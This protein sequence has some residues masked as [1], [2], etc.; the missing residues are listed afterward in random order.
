M[1]APNRFMKN[2]DEITMVNMPNPI[3]KAQ[4]A[5]RSLSVMREIFGSSVNERKCQGGNNQSLSSASP[6][7]SFSAVASDPEW[8][9]STLSQIAGRKN[10]KSVAGCV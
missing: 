3:R 9:P 10:L 6:Q 4:T 5:S 2:P 1:P 8:R 7:D